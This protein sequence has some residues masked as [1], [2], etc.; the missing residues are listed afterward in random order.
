MPF[1]E[2]GTSYNALI[3]ERVCHV[4]NIHAAIFKEV[5]FLF[6]YKKINELLNVCLGV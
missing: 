2:K 5:L 3:D 4:K 1:A 6:S